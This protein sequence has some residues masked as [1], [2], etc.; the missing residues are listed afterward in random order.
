MNALAEQAVWTTKENLDRTI[1][2]DLQRT[3]DAREALISRNDTHLDQ[4]AAK[5]NE[6]RVRS[7]IEL[8]LMGERASAHEDD[9]QYGFDL[10]LI[11][12][13]A[14]SKT[15]LPANAIYAEILPRGL[16]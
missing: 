2:I 7:V 11:R 6:P 13:D 9:E 4:L 14:V 5:L 3:R 1:E 10:D 15:T 12:R 16:R 8:M